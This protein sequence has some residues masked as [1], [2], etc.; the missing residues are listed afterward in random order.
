MIRF[1][2]KLFLTNQNTCFNIIKILDMKKNNNNNTNPAPA[3]HLLRTVKILIRQL[4]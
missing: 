4:R 2:N 3:R 1:Y